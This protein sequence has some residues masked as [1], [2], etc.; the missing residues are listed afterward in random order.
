MDQLVK[1][2]IIKI[3]NIDNI[4]IKL[5]M[6]INIFKINQQMILMLNLNEFKLKTTQI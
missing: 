3:I 2:E 1:K 4:Y 6:N 5:N